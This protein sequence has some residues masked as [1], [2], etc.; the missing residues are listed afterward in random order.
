MGARRRRGAGGRVLRLETAMAPAGAL[1]AGHARCRR[2]MPAREIRFRDVTLRLP[3]AGGPCS[4]AS[5]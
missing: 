5:T 1:A 2:G 3:T 4:R